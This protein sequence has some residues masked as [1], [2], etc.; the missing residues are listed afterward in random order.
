MKKTAY[1][2][3]IAM[4]CLLSACSSLNIGKSDYSCPGMPHGVRCMSARKVYEAMNRGDLPTTVKP[5]AT[6]SPNKTN[7]K[8]CV[9]YH[10]S[11]FLEVMAEI[12]QAEK[13]TITQALN[14]FQPM[15]AA[16][17]RTPSQVMRIWFAPW[18]D[19]Q[20]DLIDV[21]YLYTEIEPRR[22]VAGNPMINPA[23]ALKPL[24]TIKSRPKSETA[25]TET[26][27]GEK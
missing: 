8:A 10:T 9:D 18:E 14:T 22:W 23:P 21:G 25:Q 3:L 5:A 17:L 20:G 1:F 26:T 12:S 27:N 13:A 6:P 19:T 4:L 2:P 15:Q 7:K 24:Q 11:P 16:A